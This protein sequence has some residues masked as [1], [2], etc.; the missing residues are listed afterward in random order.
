MNSEPSSNR[1]TMI[2][3]WELSD[4]NFDVERIGVL[5]EKIDE[6][7][8]KQINGL[9]V[10]KEGRLLIEKYFNGSHRE[11]PHDPRSVGKTFASA[12]L[13]IAI[14]DGYLNS[15]EQKLSHFY[16]LQ[17]YDHYDWK[18]GEVTLKHLLTMSSG[19]DGFDFDPNS[20]GNEENM[21]PQ[22]DWVRWTLNLPMLRDCG[23]GERW[24]YFTAGIVVLGDILHQVLP[25]GLEAYAHK[26]LFQPL[27]I[28]NYRWQHTPQGVANTAGGIQL[29]PLDFAKF[30]YLYK[31]G[32]RWGEQ[33]IL[34]VDWVTNSFKPYFQTTN[35]A[36][37]YGY[38]W[39]NQTYTVGA[40]QP[41]ETF[42]CGGNGGNK[43][44]VFTEHD[45]VV[46]V[47]ASAYGQRYMHSQVDEMMEQY[48]LPAV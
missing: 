48:I 33:Q 29:T 21:Y 26:T 38:L 22:D 37:Q 44:Y 45:L 10:I 20:I 4:S 12:M 23:P 43:I 36:D 8:F 30:G 13:G 7:Y 1:V 15:V 27:G 24:F 18:K 46:V 34:P 28:S 42:Y 31:N 19:F 32:G 25:G 2:Q 47:T 41:F 17:A 11:L 3:G 9:V 5:K 40:D 39:W 14:R 6:N 35:P 16:D